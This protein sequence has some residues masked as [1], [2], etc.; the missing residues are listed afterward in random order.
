MAPGEQELVRAAVQ[1]QRVHE[2]RSPAAAN[3]ERAHPSVR[4]D[5]ER[6]AV[7]LHEV[8]LVDAFLLDVRPGELG[9][10]ARRA[11][12]RVARRPGSS[13][14]DADDAAE[15]PRPHERQ[16]LLAHV[17]EERWAAVERLESRPR[18]AAGAHR[19]PCDGRAEAGGEREAED[20]ETYPHLSSMVTLRRRIGNTSQG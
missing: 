13:C 9:L 7:R 12:D 4:G 20:S 5:E 2:L 16:R 3:V 15:P 19:R 8:G 10:A 14:G 6:P 1:A 17:G 18:R 11:R